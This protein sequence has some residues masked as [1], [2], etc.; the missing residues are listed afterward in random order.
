MSCSFP[1]YY[2]CGLGKL[3][4]ICVP[5]SLSSQMRMVYLIKVVMRMNIIKY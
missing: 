4:N 3:L 5:T 1:T 2:L